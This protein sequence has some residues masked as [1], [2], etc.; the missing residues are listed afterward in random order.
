MLTCFQVTSWTSFSLLGKRDKEVHRTSENTFNKKL[1]HSFSY[2]RQNMS[3]LS[4]KK[5]KKLVCLR[6]ASRNSKEILYYRIEKF[7]SVSNSLSYEKYL[8]KFPL[9]LAV[10]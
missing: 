4:Q 3:A 8:T 7:V 6:D 2:L 10:C 9:A 1:P 5:N